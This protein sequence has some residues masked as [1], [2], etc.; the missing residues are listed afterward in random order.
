MKYEKDFQ[1]VSFGFGNEKVA[2]RGDLSETVETDQRSA[3]DKAALITIIIHAV[4]AAAGLFFKVK[5]SKKKSKKKK[6]R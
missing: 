6:K 1:K 4:I 3:G 5:T 2:G